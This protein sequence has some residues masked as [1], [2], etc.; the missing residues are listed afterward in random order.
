MQPLRRVCTS[1]LRAALTVSLQKWAHCMPPSAC[2]ARVQL[3]RVWSRTSLCAAAA[4]YVPSPPPAHTRRT[5]AAHAACTPCAH[6]VQG[7]AG[8]FATYESAV[9]GFAHARA[10]TA[11]RAR[12]AAKRTL[13]SPLTYGA[14]LRMHKGGFFSEEM[15][16]WSLPFP[17]SDAS[18]VRRT[19]RICV[20]QGAL[21]SA[22]HDA[23]PAVLPIS[24]AAYF[25]LPSLYSAMLMAV[26]GT[27]FSLLARFAWG[28]KLLLA[29]PRF[30]TRGLFSHEGPTPQQLR[31]TTFAMH[32]FVR[33]YWARTAAT[34]LQQPHAPA[35]PEH[36][37]SAVVRVMGP[38]PG[39]VAT[40]DMLV[41]CARTLLEERTA[42]AVPPGVYTPGAVFRGGTSILR[43]LQQQ[44]AHIDFALL[45]PPSATTPPPLAHL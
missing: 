33:G 4:R 25:T 6:R 42:L 21:P 36:E 3:P 19:Q 18:V 16:A 28:R 14:R 30:F 8:H 41:T 17:G 15:R 2:A 34:L 29:F 1:S 10:L 43:R 9:H 12:A 35:P 37:V 27:V 7:V 24:Y 13:R 39:Y 11:L 32:F 20:E 23:S 38:E 45:Q 26:Y 31:D 22:P 44:S 40:S 5:R